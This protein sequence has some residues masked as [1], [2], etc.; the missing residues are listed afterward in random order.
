MTATASLT[1]ELEVT[2]RVSPARV[3]GND[4]RVVLRDGSGNAVE[5][6]TSPRL[7]LTSPEGHALTVADLA[8]A[9]DGSF[10]GEVELAAAGEW[11]V[12]VSQLLDEFSEPSEVVF[13]DVTG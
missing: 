5:V 9:D 6:S 7:V 1:A 3:G 4:V 13:V 8:L 2:V 10:E 11:R 12:E